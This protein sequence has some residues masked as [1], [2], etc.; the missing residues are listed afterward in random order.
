MVRTWVNVSDTGTLPLSVLGRVSD[1]EP[2]NSLG[3]G[4]SVVREASGGQPSGTEATQLCNRT[5]RTFPRPL[6]RLVGGA[7]GLP[8]T[9]SST[10]VDPTPSPLSRDQESKSPMTG[11]PVAAVQE[12]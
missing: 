8:S 10:T 3:E 1:G 5:N 6:P 4:L 9:T 7:E 12:L 2:S 11:T